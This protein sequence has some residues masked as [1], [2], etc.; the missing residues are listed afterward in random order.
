M[1]MYIANGTH[2]NLDFQY[3]LPEYRSYRQQNIPI[4]GQIKISGELSPKDIQC[5]ADQ[6]SIYGMVHAKELG[7]F[8]GFMIPCVYSI[9]EP[10]PAEIM[11]ELIVKNREYNTQ[12]GIKQRKEAAI[13]VNSMIEDQ[14][15]ENMRSNLKNLEMSVEEL[16]SK[17][18][19]ATFYEGVRITRDRER[20]APQEPDK[21]PV[22][23]SLLKKR[24]MF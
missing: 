18:H 23:F 5:I 12:L 10:V 20:G 24:S 15:P 22:D 16:P 21:N 11:A 1:K 8:K 3:R 14:F 6:H 17:D 19:D 4:G 13:T 7:N 9:D 2:Q